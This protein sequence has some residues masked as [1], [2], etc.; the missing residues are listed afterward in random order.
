MKVPQKNKGFQL[1]VLINTTIINA[2]LE[3]ENVHYEHMG[4]IIFLGWM[5]YQHLP[6]STR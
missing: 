4:N 6:S 1:A 3:T 5:D 2:V